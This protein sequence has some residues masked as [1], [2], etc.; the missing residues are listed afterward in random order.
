MST[1]TMEIYPTRKED[2]WFKNEY[3]LLRLQM[4]RVGK[5]NVLVLNVQTSHSDKTFKNVL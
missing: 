4:R 3:F 1:I 5:V 2:I